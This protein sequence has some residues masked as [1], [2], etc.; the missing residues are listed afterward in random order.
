MREI[1]NLRRT[2][3]GERALRK[4][5]HD[6]RHELFRFEFGGVAVTVGALCNPCHDCP[7]SPFSSSQGREIKTPSEYAQGALSSLFA[8]IA[9]W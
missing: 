9:Q 2:Q 3:C 4:L 7:F 1:C 5:P 6:A 8:R